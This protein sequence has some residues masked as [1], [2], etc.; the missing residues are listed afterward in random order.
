VREF[1]NNL[2][3]NFARYTKIETI[4]RVDEQMIPFKR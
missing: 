2:A 1:L 4:T 3:S